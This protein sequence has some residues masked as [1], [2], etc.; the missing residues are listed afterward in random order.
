MRI[1]ERQPKCKAIGGA[2]LLSTP[3]LAILRSYGLSLDK[4]GS[5][6]VTY[7]KN[8]SRTVRVK[9][10]FNPAVEQR[11]G[12]KGW[13]YRVLRSS[14]FKKMLALVPDGV[15]TAVHEFIYYTET[16]NDIELHFENGYQRKVDILVGAD[17]N[18]SKVSQQAFGD[19]HLFHTGIRLWL[20]WCDYIPDIP[21]N[22]GV[23]SHDYQHQTS[24]FPMLH[25]GKSRFEWWVVEPSWEGKPVPEDPKAY[26]MEILEDWAQPMPRSLVA[27]NFDRQIYCWEIYN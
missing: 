24:F 5:Y 23:V 4:V 27:T 26:L 16:E 1:F 17:G 11:M 9:L 13:H 15:I 25:V 2:V 12:I 21:P 14:N 20:A 7:F 8:K 22:Y 3:V 6:T 18:R 10:P 19:P